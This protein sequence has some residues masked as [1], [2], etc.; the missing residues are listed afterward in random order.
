MELIK[1]AIVAETVNRY[2]HRGDEFESKGICTEA[3]SY[4][5]SLNRISWLA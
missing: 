4:L 5:S 2:K 3:K 1:Q